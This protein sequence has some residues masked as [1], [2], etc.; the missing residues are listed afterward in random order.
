M[1]LFSVICVWLFTYLFY[2]LYWEWRLYFDEQGRY[3]DPVAGV[4]YQELAK[5]WILPVVF[6]T[7]ISGILCQRLLL[8]RHQ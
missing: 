6:F 1:L 5:F 8:V 2:S 4:V 7:L 3:F